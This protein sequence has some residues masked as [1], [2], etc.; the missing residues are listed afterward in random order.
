MIYYLSF[1]DNR[2][3]YLKYIQIC[4]VY[5]HMH[6]HIHAN[7]HMYIYILSVFISGTSFARQKF[8]HIFMQ[9]LSDNGL[10]SLVL[11]ISAFKKLPGLVPT[12]TM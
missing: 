9:F 10:V 12:P 7:M 5:T 3:S 6:I 8:I 4:N 11:S 2:I 1:I